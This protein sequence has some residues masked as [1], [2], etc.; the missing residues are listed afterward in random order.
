MGSTGVQMRSDFTEGMT[1]NGYDYYLDALEYSKTKNVY[2]KI[3]EIKTSSKAWEQG[4]SVVEASDPREREEYEEMVPVKATEGFTVYAKMR[5]FYKVMHVS[6]RAMKDHQQLKNWVKTV[7]GGWAADMERGKNKFVLKHFNKGAFTAG[8]DV[9]NQSIAG[10]VLT[11]PSGKFCYD[12]G[13]ASGNIPFFNASGNLRKSKGKAEYYNLLSNSLTA[14]NLELLWNLMTVNN[15]K[16][17]DDT[18]IEMEPN[19]LLCNKALT[20]TARR[21]LESTLI[22]GSNNNDKNVLN[23]IVELI[24]TN[25]FI[26]TNAY[27]LGTKGKG[28]IF[29]TR[30]TP[31]IDFW[32]EKRNKSYWLSIEESYGVQIK[33]WRFFGAS[34][35]D[36]S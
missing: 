14:D 4:T 28:M 6:K 36:A 19:Y 26:D 5:R 15:A 10:G 31:E 24:D 3:C 20:F 30:E 27:V 7:T 21:I 22:P 18:E 32:E 8:A 11:D 9:F 25:L 33:N 12:T 23:S 2:D 34:N 1:A 29:Y 16:N 35:L 17:E 13:D